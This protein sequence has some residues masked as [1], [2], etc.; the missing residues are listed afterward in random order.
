MPQEEKTIIEEYI[1]YVGLSID[2]RTNTLEPARIVIFDLDGVIADVRH[3]VHFIDRTI[4]R[5]DNHGIKVVGHHPDWDKFFKACPDDVPNKDMV[6]LLKIFVDWGHKIY[7]LSGRSASVKKETLEW[8]SRYIIPFDFMFLRPVENYE[9]DFR[10][11]SRWI[12]KIIE[13]EGLDK[14]FMAFDDN[15][16]NVEIFRN[17]GIQSFLVVINYEV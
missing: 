3:R 12:N 15:V 1:E 16:K 10:L 14:I 8:F 5:E 13:L 4:S 7:I 11:K 2:R 6:D 9:I 17:A